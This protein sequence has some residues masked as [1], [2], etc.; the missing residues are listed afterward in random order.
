MP[1]R[2]DDCLELRQRI[3]R[4]KLARAKHKGALDELSKALKKASGV[5]TVSEA[6][7]IVKILRKELA[8]YDEEYEKLVKQCRRLCKG[9]KGTEADD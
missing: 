1:S 7:N 9:V 3:E 4:M 5:E 6:K 2:A 8:K